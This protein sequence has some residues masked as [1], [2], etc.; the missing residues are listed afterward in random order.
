MAFGVRDAGHYVGMPKLSLLVN[1]YMWR[2]GAPRGLGAVSHRN[3]MALVLQIVCIH[4][5]V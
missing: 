5:E 1:H 4:V 2:Y 3:E